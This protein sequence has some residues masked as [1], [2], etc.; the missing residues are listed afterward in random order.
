MEMA[1]G[2][3]LRVPIRDTRAS[4]WTSRWQSGTCRGGEADD[5]RD[6]MARGEGAESHWAAMATDQ[7]DEDR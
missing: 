2:R 1:G 6:Q 4:G 3:V 5:R 7:Y